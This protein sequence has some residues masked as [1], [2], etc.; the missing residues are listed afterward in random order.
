MA[1]VIAAAYALDE[2]PL[3]EVTACLAQLESEGLLQ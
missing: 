1:G 2:P 3:S